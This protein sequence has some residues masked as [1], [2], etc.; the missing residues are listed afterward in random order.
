MTTGL[1]NLHHGVQAALILMVHGR[2]A[3]IIESRA[4]AF[5]LMR[6][7]PQGRLARVRGH[8]VAIT[9]PD[10]GPTVVWTRGLTRFRLDNPMGALNLSEAL[11]LIAALHPL[12]AGSA[13]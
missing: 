9:G 7:P 3:A 13:P 5:D 4:S 12:A 1:P 8:E 11:Q 2:S 10:S 6:S